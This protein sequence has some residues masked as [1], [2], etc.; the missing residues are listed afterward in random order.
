MT[1]PTTL[2]LAINLVIAL[3][4]AAFAAGGAYLAVRV[5]MHYM[6]ENITRNSGDISGLRT[7]FKQDIN[8]L[9]SRINQVRDDCASIQMKSK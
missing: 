4:S 6:E 8:S 1:D 9:H 3:V 7:E 5:K 2:S